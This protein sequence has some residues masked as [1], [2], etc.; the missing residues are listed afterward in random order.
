MNNF[1]ASVKEVY[2]H[3]HKETA[4][5]LSFERRTLLKEKSQ[6]QKSWA[7]YFRT[8]LNRPSTIS[9][10][11]LN[12]LPQLETNTYME[13]L[14]HLPETTKTVQQF[15]REK[16]RGSDAIPAELYKKGGPW[17]MGRLPMIFRMWC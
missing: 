10:A 13:R 2:G 8:V 15:S 4:P 12:R 7:E 14:P 16:V 5:L 1:F 11:A 6:I 3:R 17:L 9:N